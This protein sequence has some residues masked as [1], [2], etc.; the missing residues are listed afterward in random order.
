MYAHSSIVGE[1]AI[2]VCTLPYSVDEGSHVGYDKTFSTDCSGTILSGGTKTCTITN[3]DTAPVGNG[4]AVVYT[5]APVIPIVP[6]TP[7]VTLPP[8][9]TTSPVIVP[10]VTHNTVTPVVPVTRIIPHLPK[11]GFPPKIGVKNSNLP[12]IIKIPSIK[13]DAKIE[14]LGLSLNGSMDSPSGAKNVAWFNLGTYPGL[15]GS[16]VIDGHSGYKNNKPAVFDNLYKLTIGDEIFI[17]N[18]KGEVVTF[19]VREL[20]K[21][22]AK[23][24]ASDVFTSNDG[25][26]HL[27]LITCTG[28]WDPIV[29]SHASRLVVFADKEIK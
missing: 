15:N 14:S 2:C 29:K 6:I 26:A 22:D 3:D 21:Y 19:V 8:Q 25:K 20:K 16:A 13:I 7:V 10:N 28:A 4:G 27:N 11:T 24:D 1:T 9:T 5:P 17:Q 12:V 23:A 18:Q